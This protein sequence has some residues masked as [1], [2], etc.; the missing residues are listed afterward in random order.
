[1]LNIKV[2]FNWINTAIKALISI[3]FIKSVFGIKGTVDGIFSNPGEECPI[4]TSTP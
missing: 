3:K 4:H 2:L 1:M